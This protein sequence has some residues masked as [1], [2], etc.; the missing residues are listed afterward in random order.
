VVLLVS[1]FQ[2]TTITLHPPADADPRAAALVAALSRNLG[3]RLTWNLPV[4]LVLGIATAGLAPLV[5]LLLRTRTFAIGE[6]FQLEQVSEWLKAN[7]Y[8]IPQLDHSVERLGRA[9]PTFVW[10]GIG[11]AAIAGGVAVFGNPVRLLTMYDPY[12]QPI[13]FVSY[14]VPLVAGYM[15]GL[16]GAI[17]AQKANVARLVLPLNAVLHDA[18]QPTIGHRHPMT[19]SW[20]WVTTGVMLLVAGCVWG[21]PMMLAAGAHRR[22]INEES[23]DLR[24]QIARRIEGMTQHVARATSPCR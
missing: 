1:A 9:C 3:F 7:G 15:V 19:F 4:V 21:F 22:Y 18:G 14:A 10:L 2:P 5:I 24:E 16:F 11:C 12:S 8:A 23:L 13:V 17:Q 6:K 20:D